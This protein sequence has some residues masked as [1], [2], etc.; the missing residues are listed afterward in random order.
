MKNFVRTER[1]VS[2]YEAALM[3]FE[4]E[5]KNLSFLNIKNILCV[6]A[7]LGTE[8]H[9]LRNLNFDAIG[10]DIDVMKK[11]KYVI[12]GTFEDIPFNNKRFDAVYTNSLD[13]VY[14]YKKSIKEMSR[15]INDNGFLILRLIP[16]YKE[17]LNENLATYESFLWATRNDIIKEISEI[18]NYSLIKKIKTHKTNELY[19][20]KKK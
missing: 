13:H 7:R 14:D 16:G 12:Y 10:I 8:V 11:S 15:V 18:Y 2:N 5:F 17:G 19:I 20:L 4:N 1:L 3:G 6:A 9:A